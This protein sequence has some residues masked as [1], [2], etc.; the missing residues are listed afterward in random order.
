LSTVPEFA[1]RRDV[2]TKESSNVG[3]VD[4]VPDADPEPACDPQSQYDY[5]RKVD[6]GRKM[7]CRGRVTQ[8]TF[9]R[10][11]FER[12]SQY[13]TPV[14]PDGSYACTAIL[15]AVN[16]NNPTDGD[17]RSVPVRLSGKSDW[18]RDFCH[19]LKDAYLS[20][21]AVALVYDIAGSNPSC[22]SDAEPHIFLIGFPDIN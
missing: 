10:R 9:D 21:G 15:Q 11:D 7:E 4:I 12:S 6:G 16:P 2:I 20:N 5:C 22:S 17:L 14:R 18:H 8:M 3:M 19:L 1:T 13:A